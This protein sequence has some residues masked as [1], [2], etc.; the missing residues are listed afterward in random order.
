ML[1]KVECASGNGANL[2]KF[3]NENVCI[4]QKGTAHVEIASLS[5]LLSIVEKIHSAKCGFSGIYIDID[6]DDSNQYYM[7]IRDFWLE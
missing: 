4:D 6:S 2:K 1:F 3:I 7:I 5:E